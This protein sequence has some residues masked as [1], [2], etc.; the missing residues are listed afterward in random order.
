M[1]LPSLLRSVYDFL[2]VLQTAHTDVVSTWDMEV[3][4]NTLKWARYAQQISEHSR[5]KPYENELQNNIHKMS[6]LPWSLG[7]K[8]VDIDLLG[9]AIHEIKM[10][11]LQNRHLPETLYNHLLSKEFH[12]NQISTQFYQESKH[13]HECKCAA[14]V[15]DI[16]NRSSILPG[17]DV[18]AKCKADTL[19]LDVLAAYAKLILSHIDA[20]LEVE[21]T[22]E[23][24]EGSRTELLLQTKLH[25]VIDSKHGND[26]MMSCLVHYSPDSSHPTPAQDFVLTVCINCINKKPQRAK[27][28]WGSCSFLLSK[29][30]AWHPSLCDAYLLFLQQAGEKLEPFYPPRELGRLLTLPSVKWNPSEDNGMELVDLM[31]RYKSLDEVSPYMK[32]LVIEHLNKL[33]ETSE[34]TVWRAM[35]KDFKEKDS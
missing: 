7:N 6:L 5:G 30:C 24:R 28:L 27:A 35:L 23:K 25:R 9:S 22:P 12:I 21:T 10:V 13:L 33:S 11:L 20:T 19:P 1:A 2:E 29:A 34:Y 14:E 3:L 16:L 17:D 26:I 15:T 31:K 8:K 18:A 32:H 4:E